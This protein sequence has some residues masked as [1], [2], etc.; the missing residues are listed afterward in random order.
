MES[1]DFHTRPVVIKPTLSP[2][3]STH[4]CQC[5]P[6]PHFLPICVS[7]GQLGSSNEHL[8]TPPSQKGMN[9]G[10]VGT[11]DSLT[12]VQPHLP[13]CQ[14]RPRREHGHMP[15]PGGNKVTPSPSPARAE[16]KSAGTGGLNKIQHLIIL[17]IPRF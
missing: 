2:L 11:E 13:R 15:P 17:N 14:W 16:Q 1:Q 7:G 10:L 6:R 4:L 5:L 3:V 8:P 9:G 12:S